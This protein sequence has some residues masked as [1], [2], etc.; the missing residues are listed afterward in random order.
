MNSECNSRLDRATVSTEGQVVSRPRNRLLLKSRR[1]P[2]PAAC[3]PPRPTSAA[4]GRPGASPASGVLSDGVRNQEMTRSS[5]S[6]TTNV[7]SWTGPDPP[8][9]RRGAA[10]RRSG[11]DSAALHGRR[12]PAEST[13]APRGRRRMPRRNAPGRSWTRASTPR[14]A[15]R[16]RGASAWRISQRLDGPRLNCSG[17][18]SRRAPAPGGPAADTG[19]PGRGERRWRPTAPG[20][21]QDPG[22]PTTPIDPFAHSS[23]NVSFG[24]GTA[25]PV[26][27]PG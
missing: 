22:G 12:A 8:D 5:R 13:A 23:A 24:A 2:E 21:R 1:L 18:G 11:P 10:C 15:G 4:P 14:A 25:F 16:R 3:S 7:S 26:R 27:T 6:P 20:A 19:T 17:G 9:V